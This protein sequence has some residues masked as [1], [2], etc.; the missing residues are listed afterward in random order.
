M[1]YL[2]HKE[3]TSLD[4]WFVRRNKKLKMQLELQLH[5]SVYHLFASFALARYYFTLA[6]YKTMYHFPSINEFLSISLM[7][8]NDFQIFQT[9][10][11]KLE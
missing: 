9:F 4:L 6:T 3:P 1:H 7:H 10:F 5:L 8:F 2:V 11:K